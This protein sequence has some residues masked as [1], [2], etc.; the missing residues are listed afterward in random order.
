MGVVDGAVDLLTADPDLT[1]IVVGLLVL[2]FGGYFF[3]RRILVN[4]MREYQRGK[5]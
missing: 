3:L 4:S 1:V 2:V 5:R